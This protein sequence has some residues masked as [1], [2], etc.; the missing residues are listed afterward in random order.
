M[1]HWFIVV[2][3]SASL[4]NTPDT[5]GSDSVEALDGGRSKVVKESIDVY[6]GKSKKL[7][8][9]GRRLVR[10]LVVVGHPITPPIYTL[11]WTLVAARED[12]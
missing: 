12:N 5:F 1:T 7:F 3:E 2:D 4:T 10:S 11:A 6:D 8:S 9:R